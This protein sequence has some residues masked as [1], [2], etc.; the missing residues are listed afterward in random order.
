MTGRVLLTVFLFVSS[1][2]AQLDQSTVRRIT[3]RI[4]S[5][6]GVACDTTARVTLMGRGG[7][8]VSGSANSDCTIQF[9]DVPMG[10]YHLTVSGMHFAPV[11]AGD[12]SVGPAGPNEM[13]V[14]VDRT[15]GAG[16]GAGVPVPP[17]VGVTELNIPSGAR[18]EF[19]KANTLITR[20]DWAK[21]IQALNKAIAIYPSYVEAY[22]NLGVV[23]ARMGDRTREREALQKALSINDHFAPAYL[24][25]GR[26][27]ITAEDFPSAEAAL[28]KAHSFDPNDAMTMVL[29]TYAQFV[30]RHLDE[31]IATCRTA[32]ALPQGQH[33]FVH[34]VA[35]RALEQKHRTADAIAELELF[36]KEEPAGTRA[37]VARKELAGLHSTLAA[38]SQTPGH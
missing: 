23:Y 37:E 1:V 29:L 20:Q 13:E 16:R 18:K 10:S 4:V 11:D 21:A 6:N 5:S 34:Q 26:M 14:K 2:A 22:N 30:D 3:F 38:S 36:L 17:L 35:A 25:L 9:F 28:N 7:P 33:A 27:N 24:N 8:T 31:A 12:I 19:D 32:H 15:D